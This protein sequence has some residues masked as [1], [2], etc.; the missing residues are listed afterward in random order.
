MLD[1]EHWSM[2]CPE[3]ISLKIINKK[4]K[5]MQYLFILLPNSFH[6]IIVSKDLTLFLF[7]IFLSLFNLIYIF[8]LHGNPLKGILLGIH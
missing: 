1:T 3:N 4:S 2:S 5:H 6:R 8:F 7:S